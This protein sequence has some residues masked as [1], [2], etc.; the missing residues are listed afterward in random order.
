MEKTNDIFQ[1]LIQDKN[2]KK[3]LELKLGKPDIEEKDLI[4][5]TE[6]VLNGKTITGKKNQV[7]FEV[8]KL[9][10]NLRRV[11]IDNL[12]IGKQEI[13]Y[14]KKIQEISFENCKITQLDNL[15]HIKK[16]SINNSVVEDISI[17]EKFS[18][19]T[20]L[21]LINI[22]VNDFRFLEK[23]KELKALKIK[24]IKNIAKEKVDFELPI[25]YLSIAGFENL[26]MN[27]FKNYKNLKTMSIERKK[28]DKW[29]NI[30]EEIRKLN[31]KILID[32]IYEF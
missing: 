31:I 18:N 26:D 7:Y 2:L 29:K 24:N 28:E 16:L 25:E 30:L 32:D 4:N 27:F 15:K 13:E 3:I 1:K 17:I 11:E 19:L 8:I 9:F 6:I 12:E 23:L 14:L 20:D 21:E 10:P 5:I 22:E